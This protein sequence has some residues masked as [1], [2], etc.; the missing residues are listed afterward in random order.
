MA[1]RIHTYTGLLYQELVRNE[2]PEVADGRLP[3]VLPIRAL[4]EL[5]LRDPRAAEL[6]RA[7]VDWI[8]QMDS[9]RRHDHDQHGHGGATCGQRPL[10]V[11]LSFRPACL[12]TWP[13]VPAFMSA[14]GRLFRRR[15][16]P[17]AGTGTARCCST[18]CCRG[19]GSAPEGRFGMIILMTPPLRE[20]LPT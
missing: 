17:P 5:W 20:S 2:A 3:P 11:L 7:F 16:A 4:L 1:L 14:P 6:Q 13:S 8:R 19:H 18:P 10:S 15:N 9:S 12:S